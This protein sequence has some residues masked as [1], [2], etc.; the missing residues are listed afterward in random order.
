ME[1][2]DKSVREACNILNEAC[3]KLDE[4]FGQSEQEEGVEITWF[5]RPIAKLRALSFL[6]ETHAADHL[7]FGLMSDHTL[8]I[9]YFLD[10]MAG[11]IE[12]AEDILHKQKETFLRI[13]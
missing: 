11:E 7:S 5:K 8:G 2:K 12:Q 6:L 13:A 10:E 4:K 9:A 3:Q 1:E